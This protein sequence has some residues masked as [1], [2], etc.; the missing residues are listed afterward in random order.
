MAAAEERGWAADVL[1]FET[2]LAAL[3]WRAE[4]RRDTDRTHNRYDRAALIALAPAGSTWLTCD[5]L[6]A[7]AAGTVNVEHPE[8]AGGV[9]K[10][11]GRNVTSATLRAYYSSS[12]VVQGPRRRAP[13]AHR[14]RGLRVLR[15]PHRG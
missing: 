15:P 3:H 10:G 14:R 6:G 11:P 2:R 9:E 7:A 1:A 8:A 4:E 5:A 12:H 13:R